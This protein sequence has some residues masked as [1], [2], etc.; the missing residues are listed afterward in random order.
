MLIIEHRLEYLFKIVEKV[1][2]MSRGKIIAEGSPE[3]VINNQEVIKS[4]FGV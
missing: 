1:F 2:A 4:Y 3:E